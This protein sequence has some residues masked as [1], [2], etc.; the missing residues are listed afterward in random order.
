MV[1]RDASM[2]NTA[3]A[4]RRHELIGVVSEVRF[5]A[6]GATDGFVVAVLEGNGNGDGGQV[7]V[8]NDPDRDLLAGGTY[9]FLGRHAEHPDHGPQFAFST[10]VRHAPHDR[11]GIIQ[12]LT[13]EASHVGEARAATLWDRYGSD[14]VAMLRTCPEVVVAAGIMPEGQA[15]AAAEALEKLAGLE[16]VRIDLWGLLGGRGFPRTLIPAAIQRWGMRAPDRVRCNPFGMMLAD[17][18]GCGFA[19]CDALYLALGHPPGRLKRQA[20]CVWQ[21]I[22]EIGNNGDTWAKAEHVAQV[23]G[24]KLPDGTL[25]A[26]D[27]IRLAIRAKLLARWRDGDGQLWLAENDHATHEKTVARCV[28]DL[29]NNTVGRRR[30]GTVPRPTRLPPLEDL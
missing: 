7:V 5:R 6:T 26:R 13:R 10:F 1:F 29:V 20:L 12:Y 2:A 16:N 23:L 3:D 14:A 4:T 25:R 15:I 8:G 11:E 22:R 9:R 17:L 24:K 27:A 18:P 19:R 21:A 30:Y 28:T